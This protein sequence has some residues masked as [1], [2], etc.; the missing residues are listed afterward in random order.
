MLQRIRC[1]PLPSGDPT[2]LSS[3]PPHPPLLLTLSLVPLP[4]TTLYLPQSLPALLGH[5]PTPC[6][7]AGTCLSAS[8]SLLNTV[9][10]PD[11]PKRSSAH[12][13]FSSPSPRLSDFSGHNPVRPELRRFNPRRLFQRAASSVCRDPAPVPTD[14]DLFFWCR[15]RW[16][17][18]RPPSEPATAAAQR[19]NEPP[20]RNKP[21][22]QRG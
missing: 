13:V 19:R 20:P 16:Q 12:A 8:Q 1:L 7:C 6:A 5:S 2:R 3:P 14:L 17:V 11:T 18:T 9:P 21:T 4:S 15:A 10:V 22:A